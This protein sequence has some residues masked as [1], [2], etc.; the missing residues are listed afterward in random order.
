M[1]ASSFLAHELRNDAR[2]EVADPGTGQKIYADRWNTHVP[3]EIAAGVAETNELPDPI[4]AGERL[5]LIA[6]SVG[7]G[8]SRT[9]T[10]DHAIDATGYT[11]LTFA[12][13]DDMAILEGFKVTPRS[14]APAYEWRVTVTDGSV[15]R[16]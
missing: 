16:S 10:A 3:L 5:C 4:K 2:Y 14:S 13:V 12:A 9:V 6:V 11:A 8:G 15:T 1:A 7:A